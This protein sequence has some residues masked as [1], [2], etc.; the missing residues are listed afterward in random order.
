MVTDAQNSVANRGS[1]VHHHEHAI[2][3]RPITSTPGLESGRRSAFTLQK[4]SR[5]SGRDMAEK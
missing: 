1:M 5:E 3:L 4:M 2:G